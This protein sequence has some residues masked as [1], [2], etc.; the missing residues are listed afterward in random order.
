MR[1]LLL[2]ITS[3]VKG[4]VERVEV[5]FVQTVRQQPQAFA[6]ALIMHDLAFAQEPDNILDLIIVAEP[7]D[8][9]IRRACFLLP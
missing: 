6:E 3:L 4:W 7:Q 9:V 8:V 2:F 5:L 1:L